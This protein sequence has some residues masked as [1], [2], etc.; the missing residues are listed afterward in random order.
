MKVKE[1]R[2]DTGSI[3]ST[4]TEVIKRARAQTKIILLSQSSSGSLPSKITLKKVDSLKIQRLKSKLQNPF[5]EFKHISKRLNF[6]EI[7]KDDDHLLKAR[8]YSKMEH[9]KRSEIEKEN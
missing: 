7:D 3:L 8:S 1:E 9:I 6:E 4:S 5:D 2:L